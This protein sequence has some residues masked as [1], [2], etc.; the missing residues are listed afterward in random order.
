MAASSPAWI[1]IVLI[2]GCSCSDLKK[3]LT[4]EVRGQD[5]AEFLKLQER[6]SIQ[7]LGTEYEDSILGKWGAYAPGRR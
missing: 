7:V 6:L 5:T 1:R 3:A 2:F 4:L